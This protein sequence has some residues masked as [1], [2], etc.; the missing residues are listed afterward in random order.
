MEPEVR[1]L[2]HKEGES[3]GLGDYVDVD[4]TYWELSSER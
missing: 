1:G 2:I 3:T 4:V